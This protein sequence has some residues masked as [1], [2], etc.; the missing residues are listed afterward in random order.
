MPS[1][2]FT[3]AQKA[4]VRYYCGY[5]AS[6]AFGYI[7]SPGMATLDAQLAAMSDAEQA[8]VTTNFLAVLPGLEQALNAMSATLDIATAG[9]YSRNLNE[10]DERKRQYT[11]LRRELCQ[12]CGCEPGDRLAAGGRVTPV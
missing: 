5:S 10:Y 3:D 6:A 7:L 8:I 12:F 2:P 4:Q 11:D 9:P 1:V